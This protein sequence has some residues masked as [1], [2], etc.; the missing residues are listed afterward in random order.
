MPASGKRLYKYTIQHLIKKMKPSQGL[1]CQGMGMVREGFLRK[2]WC[3]GR[4]LSM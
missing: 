3:V 2:E 4:Y 1:G